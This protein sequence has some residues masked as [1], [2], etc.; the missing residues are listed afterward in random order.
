MPVCVHTWPGHNTFMN[1]RSAVAT[2]PK[3]AQQAAIGMAT[4]GMVR[5]PDEV[6]RTLPGTR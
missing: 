5:H 3:V 4:D 2:R 1:Q 6:A